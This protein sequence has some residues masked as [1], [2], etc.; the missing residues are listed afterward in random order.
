MG[1]C[2]AHRKFEANTKSAAGI[3]E[4]QTEQVSKVQFN[5][6]KTAICVR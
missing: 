3:A 5:V 6:R 2:G 1:V 4:T